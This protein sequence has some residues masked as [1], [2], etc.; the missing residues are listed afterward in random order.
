MTTKEIVICKVPLSF[1]TKNQEIYEDNNV[2]NIIINDFCNKTGKDVMLIDRNMA[3]CTEGIFLA[4]FPEMVN[5][6]T[7]DFLTDN[8][9]LNDIKYAKKLDNI[10]VSKEEYDFVSKL[11]PEE[12]VKVFK[13]LKNSIFEKSGKSNSNS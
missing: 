9:L 6:Y 3:V 12:I 1:D 7:F 4:Y 2:L 11:N 13:F 10:I 8:S 5:K